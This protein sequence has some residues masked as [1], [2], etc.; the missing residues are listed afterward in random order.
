MG[1]GHT[2]GGCPSHKERAHIATR[3]VNHAMPLQA[4]GCQNHLLK[5]LK[6]A[7]RAGSDSRD[8]GLDRQGMPLSWASAQGDR[9]RRD[10]CCLAFFHQ[11]LGALAGDCA[12]QRVSFEIL[13][14][15]PSPAQ[16]V[17][18]LNAG[19]VGKQMTPM[20]VKGCGGGL[21]HCCC[22]STPGASEGLGSSWLLPRLGSRHGPGEGGRFLPA[23]GLCVLSL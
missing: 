21:A 18:F 14:R 4:N 7:E 15:K 2:G 16:F 6:P 8:S 11:A 5:H 17:I 10:G 9:S 20:T 1:R 13:S 22:P 3:N 12:F 23:P 19:R